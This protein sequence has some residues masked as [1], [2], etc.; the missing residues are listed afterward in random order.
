M[1]NT[2]VSTA[3]A[4]NVLLHHQ[5]QQLRLVDLQTFG[6]CVIFQGPVRHWVGIL[7]GSIRRRIRSRNPCPQEKA[8]HHPKLD[9]KQKRFR[10]HVKLAQGKNQ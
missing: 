6:A 2:W 8:T 5:G 7:L 4:Q 1:Q 10:Y 3:G 9:S